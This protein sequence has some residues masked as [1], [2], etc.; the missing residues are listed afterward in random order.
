MAA[1]TREVALAKARQFVN[2]QRA[3]GATNDEIR[4]KFQASG[5]SA[6]A[7]E[8]LW[9]TVEP[10]TGGEAGEAPGEVPAGVVGSTDSHQEGPDIG[11][12]LAEMEIS[13]PDILGRSSAVHSNYKTQVKDVGDR[14]ELSGK[15]LDEEL[16]RETSVRVVKTG[17]MNAFFS[18]AQL[19][20]PAP[21]D[22]QYAHYVETDVQGYHR[23]HWAMIYLHHP[24]PNMI[25]ATL[26]APIPWETMG[27][28]GTLPYLLTYGDEQVEEAAIRAVWRTVSEDGR[29]FL[30][31]TLASRG[32]VPSAIDPDRAKWAVQRMYAACPAD[33][34]QSATE[35]FEEL[36][37][38]YFG[39][40]VFG[41]PE[42][43]SPAAEAVRSPEDR[44]SYKGM[45]EQHP[46]PGATWTYEVYEADSKVDA[47][48]FL[49]TK[50]VTQ[51]FYYIV[52]ETPE[53]SFGRDVNGIYEE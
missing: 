21:D 2:G 18:Q 3:K 50:R 32:V 38:E 47:L 28:Q 8:E 9:S 16:G 4:Q 23:V 31:T 6:Q 45:E 15:W 19:P 36:A 44:V 10:R 7:I 37:K 17:D 25:I 12:R 43:T 42:P 40:S 22:A 24:D 29:R 34:P 51:E 48:A 27:V 26:Q 35:K 1:Q 30:L 11:A 53:G 52:V 41:A 20:S 49:E 33:Y 14:Y 46:Q 5:W 39:P 13:A